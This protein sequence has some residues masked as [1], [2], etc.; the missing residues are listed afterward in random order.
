M[1]CC[2]ADDTTRRY[3][4]LEKDAMREVRKGKKHF[5]IVI[6]ATR[7][8]AT[9]DTSDDERIE[10]N[11]RRNEREEVLRAL[12][13]S[14]LDIHKFTQRDDGDDNSPRVQYILIGASEKLLKKAAHAIGLEKKLREKPLGMRDI[15]EVYEEY[16]EGHDEKFKVDECAC[17]ARR[18][19]AA[20]WAC[21]Q[22]A[23][24]CQRRFHWSHRS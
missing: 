15:A 17:C 21:A 2:G 10:I 3:M 16:A 1:L 9:A 14:G 5:D 20:A 7:Y 12:R 22:Q 6:E 11:A 8:E 23:A 19:Q 13:A 24:E 18:A 4:G